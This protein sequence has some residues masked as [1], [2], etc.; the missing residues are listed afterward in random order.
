MIISYNWLKEYV[1]VEL[2]ADELAHLLTM[3]GLEVEG[4]ESRGADLDQVVVARIE[5]KRQHPNADKLSLCRVNTGSETLE[6]VCGAQNMKSG[7]RVALAQVGAVLPGDFKIKRSKI[8]GE[9]SHGMLCSEKE[10]GLAEASEGIMILSADAPLGRPVFDVLGLKDTIFEIGL[11]PNR[12]DCLSVIGIAR[13]VAAKLGRSLRYPQIALAEKGP[14]IASVTSVTVEDKD[15]CPRYAARYIS[16]CRIASSPQ[17][18]VNR[19]AAAGI[20]SI[21]NLVDVT[22]YVMLEFGQPLHA[23]DFDRLRGGRIIVR[24]AAEG[25]RFTTLDGQERQLLPSDLTIRDAEGAVALAGIMGGGNSEISDSTTNVLL[26]SAYFEPR[27]I[28]RTA[29]RLGMHSESSHRFERGVDVN[30]V[31]RALD[32]AA[33]L[34][35]ELSGGSIAKGAIDIYPQPV[36]CRV[37]TLRPERVNALLGTSISVDEMERLCQQLECTVERSANGTLRVMVP[38]F[39]VDIEREIDLVEEVA[40]LHGFDAIAVTMPTARVFSDRPSPQQRSIAELKDLLVAEG[41]HEVI[42]YSFIS[43]LLFDGI[44]LPPNDSRR[45]VIPLLNPLTEEQSVLRTTL[46]PGLL[47]TVSRNASFRQLSQ[48][49]FELRRVYLPRDGEELPAEP[50]QLGVIMTG[51]RH[52]EGWSQGGEAVDF[53]DLKGVAESIVERFRLRKVEYRA[54]ND[55]PFYHP[56]KSCALVAGNEVI[57]TLGELHPT[58]QERLDLSQPVYYLEL[59]LHKLLAAPRQEVTIAAPHRFPD[60]SRDIALLVPEEMTASTILDQVR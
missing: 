26:E 21:N 46:L 12:A 53:Y 38:T 33:S 7:D 41:L 1:D 24:R 6:I 17:W 31:G 19:L 5:E 27:S 13:E 25:E 14:A 15:L 28:R 8:R 44:L 55:E 29:K 50:L 56:G 30:G 23:F 52:P 11:T 20:R 60:V 36:A 22:N 2:P 49:L 16:G 37:I 51:L 9:E 32:R 45:R 54:A 42:N 48:R 47:Q 59:W 39:R 57:G 18:L 3:L 4:M 10:L 34:M 58:V 40:R 35:A 43:P